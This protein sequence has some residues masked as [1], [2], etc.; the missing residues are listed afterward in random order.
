MA[1]RPQY[2]GGALNVH[3]GLVPETIRQSETLGYPGLNHAL[4]ET[5][6]SGAISLAVVACAFVFP[7]P[8]P[9]NS[10]RHG[11]CLAG[12]NEDKLSDRR[13]KREG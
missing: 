5:Q 1:T 6:D 3:R 2:L 13:C 7:H 4:W 9:G 8:L 12:G 10:V 11:G